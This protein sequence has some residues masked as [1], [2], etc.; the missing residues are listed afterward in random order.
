MLKLVGLFEEEESH[1]LDTPAK[2]TAV[3]FLYLR[4]YCFS[5]LNVV[6][7]YLKIPYYIY[8]LFLA[9]FAY[10]HFGFHCS[11]MYIIDL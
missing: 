3:I 1:K 10:C 8:M 4:I 9:N 11:P 5:I 2:S 7:F 6:S